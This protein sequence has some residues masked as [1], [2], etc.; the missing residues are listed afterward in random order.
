M[1]LQQSCTGGF[2]QNNR[3]EILFVKRADDD[4]FLPGLWELPGGGTEYG[5]KLQE[6][7]QREVKEECGLDVT[8]THPLCVHTYILTNDDEDVQRVEVTF[9]CKLRKE[10]PVVLSFEHSQYTWVKPENV[11]EIELSDYMKTV[12]GDA[13]KNP[14]IKE[15]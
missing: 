13:L 2:I 15:S 10:Q 4:E 1:K 12:V 3:G 9:L 6:S 14:L 11:S 5:E 7:L 8:V